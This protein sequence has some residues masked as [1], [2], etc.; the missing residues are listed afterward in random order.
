MN[1]VPQF[2]LEPGWCK[3]PAGLC[4]GDVSGVAVDEDDHVWIS[5]R[6]EMSDAGSR[7][8][9]RPAIRPDGQV[10][11]STPTLEPAA[12]A[13]EGKVPALPVVEFDADG[14]YLR[15]WGGPGEGYEWPF[16]EHSMHVDH[17]GFVWI[18]SAKGN[19]PKEENQ[20]LKFTKDG[21]FVLQIGRRGAST[22]SLDPNNVMGAADLYVHPATN[23][24]FVA[25]GYRNRRVV[26]FDADT[27]EFHRMWGAYGN[28]PDDDAPKGFG[29]YGEIG[30]QFHTVHGIR[31]SHDELVYVA[32]RRNNRIQVFNL[33]GTYVAEEFYDR[34]SKKLGTTFSI[35]FSA[36][37]EQT[38]MYVPDATN[39]IVRVIERSSLKEV[40]SF[41]SFGQEPG[42]LQFAHSIGTDSHGDVYTTE[43]IF[44]QRIQKWSL[45]S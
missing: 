1:D 13:A 17:R 37:E 10:D 27:G 44:A 23:E 36:D 35:A 8:P 26:V 22:G 18:T 19:A 9:N 42:Q 5:H 4:L 39:G 31:V 7:T 24:L 30:Q 40:D 38:Y 25:D 12:T 20:I 45:Q 14:N 28:A 21:T 34:E 16:M 2:V 41:G 15:S 6:Y 11:T 43:V 32:D 33:D 3:L 29:G